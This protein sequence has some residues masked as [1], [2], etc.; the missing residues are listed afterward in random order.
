M[1]YGQTKSSSLYSVLILETFSIL[2]AHANTFTY[3]SIQFHSKNTSG[4][5][6]SSSLWHTASQS[7]ELPGKLTWSV[8]ESAPE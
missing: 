3:P 1:T 8:L 2:K 6:V 4:G 7:P 5:M